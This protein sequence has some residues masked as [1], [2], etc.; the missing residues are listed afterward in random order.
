[1]ADE[2]AD[3]PGLAAFGEA[4]VERARR[5]DLAGE[6]APRSTRFG[7]VL[8]ARV[9]QRERRR[10]RLRRIVLAV[11]VALPVAATSGAATAVVL[12]EAVISP[13][14]PAQ[15]PDEQTPLAGTAR[16]SPVR[17]ADPGGGLPWALRVA[18]GEDR[19]HLH[20]GR[21]GAR[22]RVRS[23][24]ARRRLPAPARRA[25]GRLRAGRDADRRARGRRRQAQGRALDRLRRRGRRASRPRPCA[26]RPA[27][28]SCASAPAGR[29]SPPCAATPRT[30]PPASR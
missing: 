6:R 17:A 10:G 7:R 4:L 24:R 1:M 25:L 21:P 26:R 28:A 13:P 15:V 27:S 23:D 20:D 19:V 18:R 5:A 12:R 14:D 9:R 3:L 22:R 2:F 29:S 16:V 8:V 11:A 30:A